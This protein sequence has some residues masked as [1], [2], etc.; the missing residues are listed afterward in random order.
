MSDER[1]LSEVVERH[2]AHLGTPWAP[3]SSHILLAFVQF[4]RCGCNTLDDFGRN[5]TEED[6]L[7]LL[8]CFNKLMSDIALEM[9]FHAPATPEGL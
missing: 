8:D 2:T 3:M 1:R 9:H 5:H 4:A 6:V 7:W